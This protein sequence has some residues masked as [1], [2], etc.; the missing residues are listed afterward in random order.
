VIVDC[1]SDFAKPEMPQKQFQATQ[2]SSS[3][4]TQKAVP[5]NPK[6]QFQHSG[7]APK[8]QFQ[9]SGTGFAKLQQ[10]QFQHLGTALNKPLISDGSQKCLV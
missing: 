2:K 3:R 8:N 1:S 6:K 5:G 4:Q 7:T 10:K 9:H